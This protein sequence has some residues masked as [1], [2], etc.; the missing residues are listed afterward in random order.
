MADTENKS[1]ADSWQI[2]RNYVLLQVPGAIL[3]LALLVGLHHWEFVSLPVAAAILLAWVV[4]DAVMYRFVGSSY[5]PGPL[6]GTDAL[7]G[8]VGTVA[9]DLCPKGSVRLGAEHWSARV[10]EG[11][12][13][14]CRGM[15][16]RVTAVEGYVIVVEAHRAASTQ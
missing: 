10:E 4:K 6:H 7:L 9:Q 15:Q 13:P 8:E 5:G 14:L 3:L 11:S 12:D 2:L 16:V 1:A